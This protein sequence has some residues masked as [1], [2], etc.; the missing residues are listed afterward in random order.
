MNGVLNPPLLPV[1]DVPRLVESNVTVT[2]ADPAKPYP[3]ITNDEPDT[4][5]AGLNVMEAVTENVPAAE[6]PDASVVVMVWTPFVEPGIVNAALKEPAVE[7]V[8]VTGEVESVVPSYLIVIVEV[9]AKPVPDAV[10]VV[11]TVPLVGLRAREVSMLKFAVAEFDDGSVAVTMCAPF[12]D[13]VA[14][15]EALNEPTLDDV[16]ALGDVGWIVPSYLMEMLD[17]PAKPVPDTETLV[18]PMPLEGVIVMNGTTVRVAA[19]E[20]IPSEAIIE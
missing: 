16:I 3:A 4:P 10:T 15:M 19:A 2:V 12:A 1:T 8:I 11:P 17:A 14:V 13:V 20:C 9:A 5:L 7:L 6:C 18:P